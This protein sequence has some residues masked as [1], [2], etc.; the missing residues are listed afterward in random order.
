VNQPWRQLTQQPWGAMAGAA[1]MALALALAI[2]QA[3]TLVAKSW[4]PFAM[5]LMAVGQFGA[6]VLFAIGLG[7]GAL[8]VYCA[9]RL[10]PQIR[11]HSGSLWA[12]AACVGGELG[13]ISLLPL[14]VLLLAFSELS[15]IGAI[16]G[17]FWKG[18]PYWRY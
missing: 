14:P 5:A 2:D 18:R 1:A 10:Y 4:Q 8:A 12:L 15:V 11:L 17:I 6:I 9:E 3:V 7:L 16:V 13:L